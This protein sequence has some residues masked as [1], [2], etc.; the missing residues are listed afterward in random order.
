LV[1]V[2]SSATRCTIH[3]ASVAVTLPTRAMPPIINATATN[4]PFEVTGDRSPYPTVVTVVI[5]HHNASPRLWILDSGSVPS[6]SRI[7][8]DAA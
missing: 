2:S 1:A 5:A 4:F 6:T 8:R 3:D 7:A